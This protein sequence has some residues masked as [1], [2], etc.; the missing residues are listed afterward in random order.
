MFKHI[1]ADKSGTPVEVNT[2]AGEDTGLVVA[3][4][5]HKTYGTKTVYFTNPTYGR[6][7]AQDGKYG[8]TALLIHDGTD[9]V[10][11]TFSEP[12]GTA[13]VADSTA[14]YYADA[15]A[16]LSNNSNIGDIMQVIN[17]TGPGDNIDMTGNYVALTMWINVDSNWDVG[18]SVSVYA[19]I[20][21]ALAGNKV[22]LEDYF[23]F[24]NYDVWQYIDIPLTDMGIGSTSIDSFR[25]EIEA[26]GGAKSP[27]FYIDEMY[28]QE[29]GA[30]IDFEVIPDKG[31]W[32]H[33]KAFQTTFVDAYNPDNADGTM[34]MLSYDKI[35]DVTPTTGYVYKR[36]S[37]GE[38]DPFFEFRITNLLDL[39]SLPYSK[40]SNYISDGTNTLITIENTYPPEMRFTLKAED[41]DRI[42]YTVD[43]KF[44]DLLCFRI[45][46]QG[47]VEQR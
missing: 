22:Y 46:C 47:Y 23:D 24:D 40:I 2:D 39:L 25:F 5:D 26:R 28:L 18:D 4:R 17:N 3:T 44:D 21:G 29:S 30:S 13:W 38:T 27:V 9:T 12:V 31:T 19:H 45:S 35:L 8:G 32:F 42:V 10:A 37:A 41:L 6:E 14:R 1:I 15:K 7:M 36:Y 11:W 16:L 20:D 33:I 34:P 43:D